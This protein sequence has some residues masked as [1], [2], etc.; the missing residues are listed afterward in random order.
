MDKC[1]S[2]TTRKLRSA[3]VKNV[4]YFE[5]ILAKTDKSKNIEFNMLTSSRKRR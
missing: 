4:G 2:E 1:C 5:I 3:N